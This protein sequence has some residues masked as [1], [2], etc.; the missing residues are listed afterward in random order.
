MDNPESQLLNE[1]QRLLQLSANVRPLVNE[2]VA[3]GS[4][5]RQANPQGLD[6]R[7]RVL[8]GLAIKA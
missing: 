6:I 1:L 2:V 7:D 3:A 8:I 5:L 4:R